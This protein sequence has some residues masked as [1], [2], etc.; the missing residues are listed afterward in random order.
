MCGI[1][2]EVTCEKCGSKNGVEVV[3]L[4]PHTINIMRGNELGGNIAIPSSGVA[5]ASTEKKQTGDI[6]HIP[7]NQNSY[8]AVEGL[9]KQKDGIIY[10]VSAL[11][12]QAVPQRQDVYIVDDAVRNEKGQVM[13][14]KAIARIGGDI[15]K[16]VKIRCTGAGCDVHEACL[17]GK[18]LETARHDVDTAVY[19]KW[20]GLRL[21][22]KQGDLL[23][24]S[25]IVVD[26]LDEEE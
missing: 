7:V 11:T 14:C 20:D 4:T 8:G 19:T 10:I 13:G 23:D 24:D 22:D 12:A 9:P 15:M 3:N 17:E 26:I 16:K 5:R 2:I 1:I 21:Y 18:W 6:C 25:Y